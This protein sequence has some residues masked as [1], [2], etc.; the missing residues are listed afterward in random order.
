MWTREYPPPPSLSLSL[1][2][3][4]FMQIRIFMNAPPGEMEFKQGQLAF[5]WSTDDKIFMDFE[6]LW[7]RA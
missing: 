1:L 4:E 3:V 6:Y 2:I 5:K 7:Y